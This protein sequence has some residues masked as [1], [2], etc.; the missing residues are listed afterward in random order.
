M[1]IT[2]RNLPGTCTCHCKLNDD[3]LSISGGDLN[4]LSSINA[5]GLQAGNRALAAP[6]LNKCTT[7]SIDIRRYKQLS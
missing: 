6:L 7:T 5:A 1:R 3:V 2:M 4:R